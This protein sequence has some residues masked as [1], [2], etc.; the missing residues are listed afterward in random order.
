M[1]PLVFG[2]RGGAGL[3]PENTGLAFDRGV[4]SGADG[5]EMDV[6]LSRDGVP[7]V[8]H[9]PTLDRT[10]DAT[11]PVADRTAAELAAVDA[12]FR[13]ERDGAFPFRGLAGGLPA[14]ADVLV[15]YPSTAFIVE[16][17]G[18]DP[19]LA[20]TVVDTVRVAGAASRVTIGSFH[21]GALEAVRAYDPA[22][23]TGATMDEIRGGVTAEL[24]TAR[25]GPLTFQAFQVPELYAG[26][27]IVTPEFV[28][29][30][31][32]AGVQVV[33]WTVNT[34]DDMRRLLDWGVDGLITD[35]PDVCAPVV[36]AWHAGRA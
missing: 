34:E 4:A 8:I 10:T 3:A 2:H 16:L 1:R 27:R 6:H 25:R 17:K 21:E 5:L 12:G 13:L 20:R 14:L 19:R 23:R 9:D 7:V 35:R 18:T 30:A 31:H 24:Y 33:V 15:R 22:I 28:R 11:G 29:R 36:A 26:Q 32:D